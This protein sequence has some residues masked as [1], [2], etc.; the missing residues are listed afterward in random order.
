MMVAQIENAEM[1]GA[2]NI[3]SVLMF[4]SVDPEQCNASV[5]HLAGV[6]NAFVRGGVAVSLVV[7]YSK[8]DSQLRKILDPQVEV[9]DFA[10]PRF[11]FG[12]PIWNLGPLFALPK[13]LLSVRHL[14]PEFVYIRTG[15][16]TWLLHLVSRKNAIPSMAEHNGMIGDEVKG[17]IAS[18]LRPLAIFLQVTEA[19]IAD[20]SLAVTEGLGVRLRSLGVD[21][22]RIVV[23]GNG[24]DVEQMV[25]M[26]RA[27]ALDS[28]GLSH[29]RIYLGFLGTLQWWQ[30]LPTLL[31]AFAIARQ[32]RPNLSLIIGGGGPQDGALHEEA[33]TLGIADGVHF[34]GHV[35]ADRRQ[36]VLSAIDIACLSATA[37]RNLEQGAS[38]LK[39]RD[40]AA[41]GRAILASRLPG[42]EA[43]EQ[44]GAAV[45]CNPDD[46]EDMARQVVV[47]ADDAIRRQKLG[48]ASRA[49]A[50]THFSWRMV[51]DR[52]DEVTLPL[53]QVVRSRRV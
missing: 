3:P 47:L 13:F 23:I 46:P 8:A 9:I 24:A 44:A 52:I 40:Y 14:R 22:R 50:V 29:D 21:P 26:P 20:F 30:G 37:D 32:E 17:A 1:V 49:Y 10:T 15:L 39:V 27:G 19:K 43:I 53:R 31:R 48:E 2:E 5:L 42:L 41:M 28:L 33:R 51:V 38:P 16:L 36:A 18:L 7:P 6:A 4:G 12:R 34:L 25:A 35:T 45:L 11:G